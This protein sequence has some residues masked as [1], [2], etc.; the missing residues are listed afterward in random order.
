MR[1]AVVGCGAMGSIYGALLASSG[2]DVIAIDNNS[3]HVLAINTHGL[4][5]TGASGDRCIKIPAYTQPPDQ[6]TELLIIAVKGRQIKPACTLAKPLL[7]TET[8]I[9]TIQNGLGSSDEVADL[10]GS[11]RLIVGV[12][13]GFGASLTAPGHAH[14]NAMKA[15]KMGAY[16]E[17]GKRWVSPVTEIFQKAGFD[18]TSTTDILAMQWEELICNAAYSALCALT[19]QTIGEVMNDPIIGPVSRNAATEAWQIAL[20]SKVAIN[21]TDPVRLVQEFAQRMPNAKP[22]VLL[23]IEAGRFSE[24]GII[25]G[26]IPWAA[27]KAGR[28][29]PINATLTALVEALEKRTIKA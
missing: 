18:A 13:Q 6:P 25:N 14:H 1:I 27:Q 8:V 4:R 10:V 24:I 22:S 5:V 9:L 21:V 19:G 12:A 7:N 28:S 2:H 29:A 16:S 20:A 3:E 11:E 26:A 17:A 15:I 23:D